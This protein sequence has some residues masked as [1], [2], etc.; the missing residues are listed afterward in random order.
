MTINCFQ[1]CWRCAFLLSA[2]LTF[3][4]CSSS[5]TPSPG[6]GGVTSSGGVTNSG[7]TT[8]LGGA[9]GTGGT[10]NTGGSTTGTG[11]VTSL[12]GVTNSGGATGGASGTGGTTGAADPAGYVT[13]GSWRGYP[14]TAASSGS[15][16]TP[17]NFSGQAANSPLCVSGSVAPAADYS[18]YA[19]VGVNLNQAPAATASVNT[20]VPTGTGVT[21]NVSNPGGSV[22]RVQIAGPTGDTDA[23]D[24]WCAPI[25]GTGGFMPWSSFNTACWDGSG[26]AYNKQPIKQLDISVPGDSVATVPFSFCLNRFA[27]TGG[28]T[29]TGGSSGTSSTGGTGGS[30]SGQTGGT[31]TQ[32]GAPGTKCISD[33]DCTAGRCLG[34]AVKGSNKYCSPQC[35]ASTDCAEFLKNGGGIRIPLATDL[36]G[37]NN[38]WNSDSLLRGAQ[39]DPISAYP[40]IGTDDGKSYCWFICP[41]N[42]AQ[43]YNSSG[44]ITGC[45]CLPNYVSPSGSPN[46]VY[47]CQWDSSVQCS[48]FKACS[49]TSTATGACAQDVSCLVSTSLQGVCWSKTANI[50][51]CVQSQQTSCDGTCLANNCSGMMTGSGNDPCVDMCCK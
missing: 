40:A 11:G 36:Q 13:T 48:I 8:T 23:T 7:G 3:A 31:T 49:S 10:A 17:V 37:S 14:W 22:L 45:A 32:P 15:T 47:N 20:V 18:G 50:E 28:T 34:T 19:M 9:S 21:V 39:C 1:V 6:T 16:I 44:A 5:S 30:S 25:T 27:E 24:R 42:A 43:G 51:A 26:T 2:A 46:S 29:G 41:A 4:A 38:R 33:A 35:S 12:G